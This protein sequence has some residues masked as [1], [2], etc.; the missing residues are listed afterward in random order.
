MPG[1]L[2]LYSYKENATYYSE[3]IAINDTTSKKNK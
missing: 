1:D 2:K 3:S